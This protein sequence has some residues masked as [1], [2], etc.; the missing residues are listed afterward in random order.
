MS[1]SFTWRFVVADVMCPIIGADF[2]RHKGLLVDLK[3]NRLLL[4]DD[5]SSVDIALIQSSSISTIVEPNKSSNK[6][7][8]V[9]LEFPGLTSQVLKKGNLK[10]PI[11]HN[12]ITEGRPI[13]QKFRRLDPKKLKAAKQEFKKLVEMG[14][15]KRSNSPWASPLHMVK[16]KSEEWRQCGDYR[17]LNSATVPDSY[18]LPHI[19]DFASQL[20]GAK[21]FSKID[22]VKAYHQIPVNNSGDSECVCDTCVEEEEKPV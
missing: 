10:H 6:F 19:Q 13:K 20:A 12:I 15:L 17:R 3:N 16:K 2:L 11:R 21:I 1:T 18:P 9:L 22:L 5:L 8:D 4:L 14:V 7:Q